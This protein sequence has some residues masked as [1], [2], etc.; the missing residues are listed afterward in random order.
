[1]KITKFIIIAGMAA[2]AQGCISFDMGP[3]RSFP[4]S[5]GKEELT[6]QSLKR[7]VSRITKAGYN[8]SGTTYK[9][10]LV[11]EGNF[12]KHNGH[13][14]NKGTPCLSVGLWPGL[15]DSKN[16]GELFFFSILGIYPFCGLPTLCSLLFEPFRDYRVKPS[17]GVGDMADVGI[18]G[19]NKYYRD[20]HR[21]ANAGFVSVSTERISR[22]VLYAYSVEIDGMRYEDK[23]RGRGYEGAV[24]FRYSRPRGSKVAIRIVD[25]PASRSDGGD[26]FSGMQGLVLMG[27]IP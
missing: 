3:E 4:D 25:S 8:D 15:S 26:G 20:V 17:N 18:I 5:A 24:Y 9:L 10:E 11:A 22:Y 16:K 27:T 1:M 19:F 21:D 6:V 7:V 13:T 14:M 2:L 12:I 23:D